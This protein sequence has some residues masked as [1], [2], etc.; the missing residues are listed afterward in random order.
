MDPEITS[1]QSDKCHPWYT[2]QWRTQLDKMP[3]IDRDEMLFLLAPRWADDIR[4][5]DR[6]QNRGPWHY[7]NLPF[8][9]NKQPASVITKTPAAA[10]LL[11]ALV[12]ADYRLVEYRL[13]FVPD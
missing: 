6:S 3:L 11:T 5:R 7:I 4:T 12:E 10:N 9:P 8:K 1:R 13:T 2:N